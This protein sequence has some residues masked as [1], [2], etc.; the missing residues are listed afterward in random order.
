MTH[1][2]VTDYNKKIIASVVSISVLIVL[3][4]ITTM[5]I[6]NYSRQLEEDNAYEISLKYHNL[7]DEVQDFTNENKSLLSGFSAYIQMNDTYADEEVYMYLDFLLRDHLD[8]IRNIAIF[9]DTTMIWVYPLEG[10]ESAIGI[11][12]SKVAGQAEDILKVKSNLETLFVGPVNLIQGGVGF[13]IRMPLIKN[14]NYWGM[15]SIVLKAER[16]F[17][18][19]ENYSDRND[20]GYLITHADNTE[21]IIFGNSEILTMSPLK[22]RTEKTLG[23]WDVYTVPTGGWKNNSVLLGGLFM[24]AAFSSTIISR[25]TYKWIISYSL[26]LKDKVELERKYTL[27]RF[28]GIYN[29]E[30]FNLRVLEEFSQATR[31]ETPIAMIYFDLD[32]FKNVN[33]TYG[34][35]TGDKVLI[36]VVETVNGIIREEDVFAR[37]GGDEFIIMLPR[38]DI[39]GVLQIAE[40]VRNE[41]EEL[42]ISQSLGVTVSVGC[43][44]WI[45]YEYL[46]SWFRRTDKALYVSKNN[47]RNKVTV[48]NHEEENN[49]FRRIKWDLAWESGNKIIDEEHIDILNRCNMVIE[50][51]LG[52]NMLE[53]T[54]R[55]IDSLLKAIE[56]HF[57]S[58]IEVLKN[59]NYPQVEEHE[60]IHNEIL[61]QSRE[62]YAKTMQNNIDT[63][64]LFQ[65]LIVQIVEGHLKNDD[66][67]YFDYL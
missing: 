33:D 57:E 34:H 23:G 56:S 1:F 16:A 54:L 51:S 6:Y 58:E 42:E 11:D 59:L 8:D 43:S 15:V 44:Q 49:I 52:K 29:R 4:S 65:F 37:W 38:A 39:N 13:I 19:V 30:Y 55:D 62:V 5:S 18:F 53:E 3:F 28:T 9:R 7:I 25:Y 48:S 17:D 20:V 10:N 31:Y 40:R 45:Q 22:F 60:D 50:S 61:V 64:E 67:K 12:L 46:E 41:I 63:A 36:S 66:V 21:N 26:I 27:D 24:L 47:G 2:K 35:S 32:H 14:D